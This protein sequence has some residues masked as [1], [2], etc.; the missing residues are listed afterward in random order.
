[1]TDRT[2][3]LATPAIAAPQRQGGRLHLA[4]LLLG[5]EDPA[6]AAGRRVSAGTHADL[7]QVARGMDTKKGRLR[8]EIVADEVR[9]IGDFLRRT[10]AEGGWR[11]VLLDGADRMNRNAA[12]ALLK[13]LEEPPPRAVLILTC[14][15]PGRLL[16]TIRSRCRMLA[17]DPL[18][19]ADVAAVLARCGVGHDDVARVLP[20]AQGAPAR[21]LRY[22][23]DADG[24]LEAGVQALVAGGDV[25]GGDYAFA[26]GVA[27]SDAGFPAFFS[28][29]CD[30]VSSRARVL[31]RG[32][33]GP[34][35][36]RLA[37]RWDDLNRIRAET[38]RSNLDKLQAVL[39]ALATMS[40]T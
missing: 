15:A 14:D 6:S 5:A 7:L 33:D 21:A 25:P 3:T 12:N 35:A 16:P 26:E 40:E 11:V 31:A 8:A 32:G 39:S 19:D 28:L 38:E 17:L 10:A 29:L 20:H 1:M 34:G 37:C 4:R 2:Q 24:A 30:E 23:G 18:P 27:R 36:L 13:V 9:P 22:L